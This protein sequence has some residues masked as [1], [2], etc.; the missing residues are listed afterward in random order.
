MS[1]TI[2]LLGAGASADAGMPLVAE[3]TQ[4]MR[5]R[6]SR[7]EDCRCAVEL[8]DGLS[9]CDPEIP[10]NYERFFEWVQLLIRVQTGPFRKVVKRFAVSRKLI[11][12]APD[13]AFALK[14][15]IYDILRGRRR[16]TGYRPGYFAKLGEFIPERGR[17]KIFTTNYDLCLEDGCRNQG[18]DVVTGFHSRSGKWRPSC[19][20]GTSP[21]INLYKLHGSLNWGQTDEGRWRIVSYPP[22]WNGE[23]ELVLG[24]GRKLQDDEPFVT[25]YAEFHRALRRAK[26]LVAIGCSFRDD[27]IKKPVRGAAMDFGM[28]VIEVYSQGLDVSQPVPRRAKEALENG[29]IGRAL[30]NARSA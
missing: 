24:P 11:E 25:L 9:K 18:I 4:E 6:L 12:A 21:G 30:G 10:S 2:F 1:R 29:E 17:L 28:K 16:R 5:Q 7:D 26:A 27:H 19:F 14:K 15:P 3:L 20:E 23:P 13:T 8:F 22:D